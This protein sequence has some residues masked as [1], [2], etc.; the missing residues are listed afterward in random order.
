MSKTHCPENSCV[1]LSSQRR[2]EFRFQPN[3]YPQ[4][5]LK[6]TMKALFQTRPRGRLKHS[7]SRWLPFPNDLR[8]KNLPKWF[9]CVWERRH[10]QLA[11]VAHLCGYKTD[12]Y[13]S[14]GK[15]EVLWADVNSWR[16]G[17]WGVC[18][19]VCLCFCVVEDK[20]KQVFV[21][22]QFDC[23]PVLSI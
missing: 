15:C 23:G 2:N 8:H 14:V 19:R 9:R 6:L 21:Q 3:T 13:C 7:V 12:L 5:L 11:S 17:D 16:A 20:D 22:S 10:V 4:V 18:H 1:C